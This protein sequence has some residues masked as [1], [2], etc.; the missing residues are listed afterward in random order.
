MKRILV[1]T[2]FSAPALIAVDRAAHLAAQLGERLVL[3]STV[4]VPSLPFMKRPIAEGLLEELQGYTRGQ[5][6]DEAE[7]IT[8][9]GLQ[10]STELRLGSAAMEL[11]RIAEAG[12]VDLVV[13]G[14]RGRNASGRGLLGSVPT[15]LAQICP[16]P[17]LIVPGPEGSR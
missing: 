6:A 14:S 11:A 10:V 4:E 2:D 7:R 15:R 3:V 16:K 13:V 5:L 1:G 12:D 8:V 17:L 9:P